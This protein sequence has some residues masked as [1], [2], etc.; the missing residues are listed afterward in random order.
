MNIK[1]QSLLKKYE[2]KSEV[3]QIMIENLIDD[4]PEVNYVFNRCEFWDGK[5]KI[6]PDQVVRDS[7]PENYDL[8]ILLEIAGKKVS[9][10][11]NSLD[12]NIIMK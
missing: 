10:L 4:Y 9:E 12:S 6:I 8:N 2:I 5:E 7:F 11:E 1:T 3:V